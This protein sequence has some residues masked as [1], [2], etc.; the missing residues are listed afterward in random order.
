MHFMLTGHRHVRPATNPQN[1]PSDFPTFGAVMQYLE[2]G[3]SRLPRGVS[4]NEPANQV[5]ANNHIFPG[6][7]AGFLGQKFDPLFISGD[8]ARDDFQAIPES[9]SAEPQRLAA[10]HELLSHLGQRVVARSDRL[11]VRNY[12]DSFERAFDL[13][14]SPAA[15]SAFE[16]HGE[17]APLR[18]RYGGSPFGQGCGPATT[19]SG[20]RTATTSICCRSRCCRRSTR[21]SPRCWTT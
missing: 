21:R 13:M 16:L 15:N 18:E 17:P 20:T 8:P 10:R 19:P 4:L 2:T 9:A 12:Q 3:A 14:T 7:F 6:F 11:V 1:E 5:S